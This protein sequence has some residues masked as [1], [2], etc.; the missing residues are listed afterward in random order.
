MRHY[1]DLRDAKW[2]LI[3]HVELNCDSYVIQNA[4]WSGFLVSGGRYYVEWCISHSNVA[5]WQLTYEAHYSPELRVLRYPGDA[6]TPEE[7]T[8][9]EVLGAFQGSYARP[10]KPDVHFYGFGTGLDEGYHR[11]V[12]ELVGVEGVLRGI[13]TYLDLGTL[14]VE[15]PHPFFQSKGASIYTRTPEFVTGTM[16]DRR[17]HLEKLRRAVDKV[18]LLE[19]SLES[20]V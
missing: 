11:R 14:M 17:E 12:C 13:G 5:H 8:I 19:R 9:C 4:G 15:V 20:L 7:R 3:R 10:G 16:S 18:E 1:E 2:H 6:G